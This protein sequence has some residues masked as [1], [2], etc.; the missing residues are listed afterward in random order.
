MPK[1]ELIEK[2]V[3]YIGAHCWMESAFL[4]PH[5]AT[6]MS[7]PYGLLDIIRDAGFSE[8]DI[9]RWMVEG[10]TGQV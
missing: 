4:T 6:N 5:P 2:L 7:D 1:D 8:E 10:R 9:D 3:K